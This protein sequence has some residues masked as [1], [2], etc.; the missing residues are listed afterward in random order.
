[1][2]ENT[3]KWI[4]NTVPTE[5]EVIRSDKNGEEITKKSC[6]LQFI[7]STRFMESSS[8]NLFYNLSKRIQKIKCK[9]GHDDKKCVKLVELNISIVTVFLNT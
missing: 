1:M 4:I 2:G 6:I 8:S 9:F 7:D 5:K 3:E